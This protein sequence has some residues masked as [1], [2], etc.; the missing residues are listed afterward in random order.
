MILCSVLQETNLESGQG[1]EIL[2]SSMNRNFLTV[3]K[4]PT[5]FPHTENCLLYL[6][7]PFYISRVPEEEH[8]LSAPHLP[9]LSVDLQGFLLGS[10]ILWL[11][12]KQ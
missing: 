6:S 2:E 12:Y 10:L 8:S 7:V 11:L 5:P 9:S 1:W 4:P 3:S